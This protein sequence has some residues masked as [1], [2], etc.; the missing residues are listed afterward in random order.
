MKF[1]EGSWI[2]SNKHKEIVETRPV[3]CSYKKI[4]KIKDLHK[5][6]VVGLSATSKYKCFVNG[7]FVSFGPQ[8]GNL[9]EWFYDEINLN[10]YLKEGFNS[11]VI[12]VLSYPNKERSGNHSLIRLNTTGLFMGALSEAA[13]EVNLFSDEMWKALIHPTEILA[14]DEHFA[15][16]YII[17]HAQSTE[18]LIKLHSVE[19]NLVTWES[20]HATELSEIDSIL[21]KHQLE[22][23]TIP[24]LT[25]YHSHFK[26]I[27]KIRQSKHHL[28]EWNDFLQADQSISVPPFTKEIIELHA[29][30]ETTGFLQLLLSGGKDSKISILSS[31]CYAYPPVH[32]E[33]G[34][35]FPVKGD[36]TDAENGQLFG[37]TDTYKVFGAENEIYEPFWFRTFRY[38]RLEIETQDQA[39]LLK[40]FNYIKAQYPLNILSYGKTSDD[41]LEKIWEISERTLRCCMHDTYEDCPFYEQL[42]Y[43]MDSRNQILYTYA[44]SMDDRLARRCMNDFKASTKMDGLLNASAPN[45]EANVIPGFSIY[46]IGMLYD[47]MMYFGDRSFMSE[48]LSTIQNILN[49]YQRNIDDNG[50]L[51]KIGTPLFESPLWSFIDWT[52]EWNKTIGVPSAIRLGP[53]TM[54]SLLYLLGLTYAI[55]ICDY[56]ELQDLAD[57][58]RNS[59]E[60]LKEAIRDNSMDTDGFIT[61]GPAV[62]QYSQHCQVFGILTGIIDSIDGKRILL[63]TLNNQDKFVQCSVAMKF[64]LFRALEQCDLYEYTDDQWDL[65][66][67]MLNKNLTTCEEDNVNSRSDCHGWGALVLYELPSS[68]LGVKPY[69]NGFNKVLI[70]PNFS[71]LTWAKGDVK[72]AHGKI[73]ID[74]KKTADNQ[75]DVNIECDD[76]DQLVI[77]KT[78]KNVRYHI[79]KRKD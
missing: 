38:I 37:F 15:P 2:V 12:T 66:R 51:K 5:D 67:D 41:S 74:W 19:S 39:L 69:G 76:V 47:H 17:E 54:E 26:E 1:L 14:E 3:L 4:I 46:Y 60:I 77:D 21:N 29:G 78:R 10:P 61:D 63:E 24:F 40:S 48:H 65:W 22:D 79:Q 7:V 32:R 25:K 13:K 9:H 27:S 31:E 53:I 52:P 20:V 16:L 28:H 45:F 72:T 35:Q 64:Y 58:Y 44:T 8:K 42:S 33:S 70:K 6:Y 11:I 73:S 68:I 34:P 36:R 62:N 71:T 30:E 23:R 56:L 50:L 55:D 57:Q 49:F 18:D 43:I 59:A 75:Y